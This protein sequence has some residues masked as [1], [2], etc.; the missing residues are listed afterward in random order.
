MNKGRQGT[1]LP[2]KK[3]ISAAHT[4]LRL[5]EEAAAAL[6]VIGTT[7]NRPINAVDRPEGNIREVEVYLANEAH[8]SS[9]TRRRN[10]SSSSC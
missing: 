4:E 6:A 5:E 1:S 7:A 8:N 9:V 10:N 2:S 3:D